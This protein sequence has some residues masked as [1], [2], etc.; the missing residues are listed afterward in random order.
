MCIFKRI[1][2]N[3]ENK[4]IDLLKFIQKF[5]KNFILILLLV[6]IPMV[7][8]F[9]YCKF[10]VKPIYGYNV[11]VYVPATAEI[12]QA[13]SELMRQDVVANN[14]L[15]R[16]E[17]I[18][19]KRIHKLYFRD[20]SAALVGQKA[21]KYLAFIIPKLDMVI[22][23]TVYSEYEKKIQDSIR[24]DIQF[25]ITNSKEQNNKKAQERLEVLFK[26]IKDSE[27]KKESLKIV[28]QKPTELSEDPLKPK[29]MVYTIRA[30]IFG[31][32]LA[33]IYIAY[34]SINIF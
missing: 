19:G 9:L 20:K 30:G 15:V 23:G 10:I 1:V 27:R 11:L 6:L 22:K 31:L 12:Q 21:D 16:V 18:A 34:K 28:V 17:Y 13:C 3:M 32:M 7:L 25:L 24:K 33:V 26:K 8:V 4:E 2:V 29:T 5:R 14:G